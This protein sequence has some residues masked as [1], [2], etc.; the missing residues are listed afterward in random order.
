MSFSWCNGTFRILFSY[1]F[2]RRWCN[3]EPRHRDTDLCTADVKPPG[4]NSS[5]SEERRLISETARSTPLQVQSCIFLDILRVASCCD[6]TGCL[7]SHVRPTHDPLRAFKAS[8]K[9]GWAPVRGSRSA[10]RIPCE[11]VE[12]PGDFLDQGI[13]HSSAA[14]Q[15]DFRVQRLLGP[16]QEW[17]RLSV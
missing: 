8:H 15:W 16:H 2:A 4:P 13:S 12:I 11:S 5:Q 14:F 1:G 9:G 17:P 6:P 3:I 10:L 7:P